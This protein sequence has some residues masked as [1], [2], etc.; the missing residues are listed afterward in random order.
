MRVAVY[1]R[2]STPKKFEAGKGKDNPFLQNPEMQLAPLMKL[3][4]FRGWEVVQVYQDRMTGS[5]G[6]EARPGY[7]Q[8]WSDA[9]KGHFKT[10]IVWRFDRFARTT[11]E[12]L[13]ALD[14]F[15]ALGV[16]F[17]SS[18]EQIDTT[19]PMGKAMFTMV[20]AFAELERA[21]MIERINAGIANARENGTKS[22]KSIGAQKRIFRRDL[23]QEMRAN[24]MSI[25]NI[26]K[27]LKVPASTIAQ[28]VAGVPKPC[29]QA[30]P[31]PA[32][33]QAL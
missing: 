33:N 20:A 1:V 24:G 30:L 23:A 21:T 28:A 10:L 7:K 5:K 19:T 18:Q 13:K 9:R 14:E 32:S 15:R 26:A 6:D 11:L 17:V 27:E 22:G 16:D 4:E 25:R 3:A 31:F 8:L 12:L 2:V 29:P